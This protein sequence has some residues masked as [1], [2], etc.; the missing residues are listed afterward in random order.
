MAGIPPCARIRLQT[1]DRSARP[2]RERALGRQRYDRMAR[3][4]CRRFKVV[5][6]VAAAPARGRH[7]AQAGI[8]CLGSDAATHADQTHPRGRHPGACRD[9]VWMRC[10]GVASLEAP[11][12]RVPACAGMT[13]LGLS[14]HPSSPGR[15]GA[16][17]RTADR[18]QRRQQRRRWSIAGNRGNAGLKPL[19]R[20]RCVAIPSAHR[21]DQGLA[22]LL[23]EQGA[24]AGAQVVALVVGLGGGGDHRS[25]G[26]VAEHELE[27]QLCP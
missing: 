21:G 17:G 20:R 18:F 11:R 12:F 5:C 13:S 19:L 23:V 7:P 26:V 16:P 10:Y 15:A 27:E 2:A 1:P 25:H 4:K 8:Q 14:R 9:P 22:L 24:H 3:P 6:T